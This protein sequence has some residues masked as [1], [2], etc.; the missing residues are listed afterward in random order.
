MS[1][2]VKEKF[3]GDSRFRAHWQGAGVPIIETKGV[4]EFP[5]VTGVRT[6][7]DIESEELNTL[8]A[9]FIK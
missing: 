1:H 7:L 2:T 6:M 5:K 9:E 8:I 3:G 4:P